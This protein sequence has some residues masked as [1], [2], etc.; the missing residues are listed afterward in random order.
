MTFAQRLAL[1]LIALAFA[2]F[3][4]EPARSGPF[5]C[6]APPAPQPHVLNHYER[7]YLFRRNA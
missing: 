1:T 2:F 4:M 7:S 3:C 5:V 6:V